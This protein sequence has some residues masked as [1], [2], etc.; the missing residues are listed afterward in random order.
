MTSLTDEG[1][2]GVFDSPEHQAKLAE[3]YRD[4]DAEG[5]TTC[6]MWEAARCRCA[7]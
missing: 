3:L 5:M 4:F 7:R 6:V 2:G 1:T